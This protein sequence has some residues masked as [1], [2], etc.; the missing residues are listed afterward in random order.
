LINDDH[1]K[2]SWNYISL[3]NYEVKLRKFKIV[4]SRYLENVTNINYPLFI[5]EEFFLS[6]FIKRETCK[7]KKKKKGEEQHRE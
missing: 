3:E 1:F 7:E 4:F 2:I 6:F 5:Y